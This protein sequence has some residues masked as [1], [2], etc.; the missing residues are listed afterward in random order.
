MR[1]VSSSDSIRTA[2]A[3]ADTP[4][5]S[6]RFQDPAIFDYL[7]SL[8]IIPS[9]DHSFQPPFSPY[10]PHHARLASSASV[11]SSLSDL[12]PHEIVVS[13]VPGDDPRFV[14]WG[15]RERDFLVPI[16]V[17][18]TPSSHGRRGSVVQDSDFSS[19]PTS[20]A[21]S[22]ATSSSG[23]RWSLKDRR[24]HASGDSVS[25]P[26]TS[27]RDS[28]GSADL[29]QR[30]LIAATCERWVA[31][32][33]SQIRPELLAGFF[34]TYRSFIRPLDLLRLL[35]T[36]FDWAMF[37]PTSPEDDAARRIVRVRTFVVLRHW[38][39]NHFSDDFVP[40]RKLRTTLTDWLNAKSHDERYR[41]NPKDHRLIKGLKKIV[42]RLKETHMALSL[43]DAQEGARLLSAAAHPVVAA[44]AGG[45]STPI[46]EPSDDDVD[47]EID[48][49]LPSSPSAPSRTR[50]GSTF[51]KIIAPTSGAATLGGELELASTRSTQHQQSSSFP[52]P[53]SQNA[54][55]RSF[56]SAL[57][58]FGRFKRMLGNRAT[59]AGQQS[60]SFGEFGASD[61]AQFEQS[62]SG[63]LLYAKEGLASFLEYYNIPL[64]SDEDD[65]A[66]TGSTTLVPGSE[67][68]AYDFVYPDG[69]PSDPTDPTATILSEPN[70]VTGLGIS[71]NPVEDGYFVDEPQAALAHSKSNQTIKTTFAPL[72][73]PSP[74]PAAAPSAYDLLDYHPSNAYFLPGRPHSGRIELDDVDLS[75][76]DDD[77]VEVKRTL[78]RLP[79]ALNLRTATT[80][81]HLNPRDSVASSVSSYGAPHPSRV[82]YAGP[83][84]ESVAYVEE[85]DPTGVQVVENF[86]LEG[87]DSDDDE[88]GDVEA[89]LRRLE[90]LVDDSAEREKARRVARQME[91]SEKLAA[92]KASQSASIAVSDAENN[93][94]DED[95]E[96]TSL[97]KRTSAA[98]SSSGSIPASF[99]S[100]GGGE[101]VPPVP[102]LPD[103]AALPPHKS[104][105]P[106]ILNPPQR[107]TAR[108]LQPRSI[109]RRTVAA[110]PSANTLFRPPTNNPTVGPA[111]PTHRSFILLCRTEILAQQFCLIERDMFRLLSWQE[112]VGGAWRERDEQHSDVLDWEMYLKERRKVE[113]GM[114][115]R[116][117]RTPAAVQGM[118]ARYNLTSNWVASEVP[119]PFFGGG[120]GC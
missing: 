13:A 41:A 5:R 76:E 116:G 90:G 118:I 71:T 62:A 27:L 91:K 77:V 79:G 92:R 86:I 111:P 38:L 97:G 32:L 75:D 96:T 50:F 56:T 22:P 107:P 80:L 9:S 70:G 59:V 45:D 34:L 4:R 6:K 21:G 72:S 115:E 8:D 64:A 89:A 73:Q 120:S 65:E 78:K 66:R 99:T 42:R 20:S 74:P 40:D 84:R 119:F 94:E 51:A 88:P 67:D 11:A 29:P 39:L 103:I 60:G 36:R 15:L 81:K 46:R 69:A 49:V 52:L 14:M 37:V 23:K 104:T 101:P 82:S 106:G 57:G 105:P 30:V 68:T 117:D 31:E 95:E 55:A 10:Q 48:S 53:N 83:E 110:R 47:L 85:G 3:D 63:D 26:G 54:I 113:L 61:E 44:E 1:E 16:S 17:P 58:T 102:A 24:S 28:V 98:P 87:I 2:K 7:Q 18:G 43:A 35:T 33:T 12:D 25:S 108:R 109:S 100:S 93:D 112:L 19:P 114:R